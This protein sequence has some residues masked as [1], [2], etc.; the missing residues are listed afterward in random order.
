MFRFVLSFVSP[1]LLVF[2]CHKISAWWKGDKE[3]F[4]RIQPES[5]SLCLFWGG[6]SSFLQLGL[7]CLQSILNL[8]KLGSTPTPWSGPFRDHGLRPWSQSPSSAVSPTHKVFSLARPFVDWSCRP[9]AQGVGVDDLL[10]SLSLSLSLL[11]SS[12]FFL[13]YF[14]SFFLSLSLSLLH[15]RWCW[16]SLRRHF[17]ERLLTSRVL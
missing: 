15:M 11:S 4:P 5:F 9:R 2:S 17:R 1:F 14:L 16:K 12:S 6:G 7:F 8:S 13:T 3:L 10:L